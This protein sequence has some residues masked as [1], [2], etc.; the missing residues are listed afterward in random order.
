[1]NIGEEDEQYTIEPVEDPVPTEEPLTAP[2]EVP[3]TTLERHSPAL[4]P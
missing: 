3:T 2:E 1:M 4:V